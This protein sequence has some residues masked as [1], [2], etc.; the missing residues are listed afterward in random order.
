V[1]EMPVNRVRGMIQVEN[2]ADHA[3]GAQDP[4]LLICLCVMC[5]QAKDAFARFHP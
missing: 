4:P 3:C 2:C 1:N 5:Q